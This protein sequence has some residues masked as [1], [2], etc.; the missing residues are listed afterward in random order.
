MQTEIN[1]IISS[2]FSAQQLEKIQKT[3][4]EIINSFGKS[5][6]DKNIK[7]IYWHNNYIIIETHTIEAKTEINLI[8]KQLTNH[9]QIK[10]K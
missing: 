1:N 4:T 3:E 5:F 7:T 6:I 8:K 2:L 9:Q 10:I